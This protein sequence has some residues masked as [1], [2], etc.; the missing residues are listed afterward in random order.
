MTTPKDI[1]TGSKIARMPQTISR[2]DMPI[3]QLDVRLDSLSRR[4]VSE[5]AMCDSFHE[6]NSNRIISSVRLA[7]LT[8]KRNFPFESLRKAKNLSTKIS[9]LLL[10]DANYEAGDPASTQTPRGSL[11]PKSVQACA[12]ARC[13]SRAQLAW[14]SRMIVIASSPV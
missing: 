12:S 3:D 8:I 7:V 10:S 4:E 5:S 9:S 14:H 13:R 2:I 6:P 11:L 1:S